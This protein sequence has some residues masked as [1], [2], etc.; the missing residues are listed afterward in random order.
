M[1]KLIMIG[2]FIQKQ[3]HQVL[4]STN[5]SFY[6]LLFYLHFFF[7]KIKTLQANITKSTINKTTNDVSLFYSVILF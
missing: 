2:L 3:K 6:S 4:E 1:E 7:R 5:I